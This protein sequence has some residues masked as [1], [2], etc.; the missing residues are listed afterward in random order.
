MIKIGITGGI[1]SGKT[2]VCR[3]WETLGA[4]VIY[5]DDL[6]KKLM[7]G[8]VKLR[9]EIQK[10]FGKEAYNDQ[11]KLNRKYLS[12]EAFQ[13]GRV[14]ELND[15]VHPRVK[16][17]VKR[18]AAAAEQE[19]YPMFVEEAA[20]LLNEG[21]PEFLDVIVL[22]EASE[23]HRINRVSKRDDVGSGHVQSRIQRQVDPKQLRVYADYIIVN[24]GSIDELAARSES[25][26]QTLLHD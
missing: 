14:Q 24:D 25:L 15:L 9:D 20:L 26:Y 13:K 1:G 7:T 6:A 17:E 12:E 11:G 18:Q 22:V 5:A 2:T 4:K 10:A 19:G 23:R 21:R 3:I 8:D 16:E